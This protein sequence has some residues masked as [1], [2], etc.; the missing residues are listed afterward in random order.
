MLRYACRMTKLLL[1]G[2]GRPGR[3]FRPRDVTPCI[4]ES[5]SSRPSASLSPCILSRDPPLSLG[6]SRLFGDAAWTMKLAS[7]LGLEHTIRREDRPKL[8]K[9]DV[10]AKY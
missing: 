4:A 1:S 7:Q 3:P 9:T 8:E 5:R 6:R 2:A 10:E